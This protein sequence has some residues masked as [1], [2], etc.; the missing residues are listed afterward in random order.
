GKFIVAQP[1]KINIV[2]QFGIKFKNEYS[3]QAWNKYLEVSAK[4]IKPGTIDKKK[5]WMEIFESLKAT[6]LPREAKS[7]I[8]NELIKFIPVPE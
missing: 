1:K 7:N 6:H 3:P 4:D 8:V 5:A 2:D